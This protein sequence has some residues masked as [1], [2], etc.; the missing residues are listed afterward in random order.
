[1]LYLF[2]TV[3]EHKK[4]S[5]ATPYVSK[6]CRLNFALFLY[7]LGQSE[8]GAGICYDMA[9]GCLFYIFYVYLQRIELHVCFILY[10]LHVSLAAIYKSAKIVFSILTTQPKLSGERG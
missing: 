6:Y 10:N 9:I 4:G 1:M 2:A 5:M 3:L 7:I 8:N